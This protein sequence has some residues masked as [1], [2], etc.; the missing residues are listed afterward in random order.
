MKT[1]RLGAYLLLNIAVSAAV[2]VAV[3]LYWENARKPAAIYAPDETAG[4]E[5]SAAL[6]NVLS[7]ESDP[8]P[9]AEPI[10]YRVRAGETIG[11][12]ARQHEITIEEIMA[13]NGLN[14]PNELAIDQLLILPARNL[15]EPTER[16]MATRAPITPVVT[17]QSPQTGLTASGPEV[18]TI[19]AVN[20]AGDLAAEQVVIVNAGG[21][22]DLAGW[23][24]VHPEGDAYLFPALRLYQTG[25]LR[26]HT[27]GGHDNVTDLFWG[28]DQ[29]VWQSGQVVQ[30]LDPDGNI[31]VTFELP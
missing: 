11:S 12:I 8:Q 23:T 10:I 14:D 24:L 28:R 16:P 18:I 2:A 19:R 30:L 5:G 26:V 29:A 6:V 15:A 13:T 1:P 3:L 20:G 27:G 7:G 4:A 21:T 22:A 31:H 25:Q 9:S 17:P